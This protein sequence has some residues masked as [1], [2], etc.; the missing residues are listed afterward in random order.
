[1]LSLD[2]RVSRLP[3]LLF[4]AAIFF[5]QHVFVL[6]ALRGAQPQPGVLFIVL[7]F[8]SLVAA[9]SI[10]DTILVAGFAVMLIVAWLLAVLAFRRAADANLNRWIAVGAMAPVLQIPAI[11]FLSTLPSRPVSEPA[12]AAADAPPDVDWAALVQGAAAGMALTLFAVAVST[13]IFKVY[14]FGLFVFSPL[15]IGAL[16]GFFANRRR[17][18][19]A[20][21]T[22][23]VVTVSVTL[24]GIALILTALEGAACLVM[25]SP[26]GWGVAVLGGFVG[27]AIALAGQRSTPQAMSCIA[28]L[29][30][31]FALESAMSSTTQFSTEQT[32]VVGAP[33]ERVRES[34]LHMAPIDEPVALP[35]RLG[36]AYPVR[37]DVLG[38]GVGA[39]RHGVFSTGTAIERVTEWELNR[40]LAFVVEQDVPAMRELSPY[41]HV[42]AP[43]VIGFFR[44]GLTRFELRARPDG[45]T[46]IVESTAHELRLDP[47]LY[48]LPMARWIVQQNNA[49][50]LAHIKRQS[51]SRALA[52]TGM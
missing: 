17:D 33:R 52:Q 25:A 3:Y 2:G 15:A 11:L 42:F 50:V 14:G 29:P 21:Q 51:E 26:L 45:A 40:T 47:V 35:F 39:V 36:V 48:W 4:S 49:R 5:S 24:G 27:R 30:L 9:P 34:I 7:P 43:H 32:V 37:G 20:G 10:S 23:R 12:P 22:T 8:R 13:L 28:L 38:E 6:L 46:E 19:G 18:V 31:I 44:T 41:P 16:A 1:M